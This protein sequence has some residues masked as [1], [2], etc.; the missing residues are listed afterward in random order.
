MQES[1]SNLVAIF[2]LK[3][4]YTNCVFTFYHF[5]ACICGVVFVGLYIYIYIYTFCFGIC[6]VVFK[7][8]YIKY[9]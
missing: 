9:L 6:V 4:K 7:G 1:R 8:L 3:K 5:V 2:L